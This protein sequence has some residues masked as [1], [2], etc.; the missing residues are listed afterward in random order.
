[1][2]PRQEPGQGGV[3]LPYPPVPAPVLSPEGSAGEPVSSKRFAWPFGKS[4]KKAQTQAAAQGADEHV[5]EPLGPSR[6]QRAFRA[7]VAVGVVGLLGAN[8]WWVTHPRVVVAGPQ[9]VSFP[10]TVGVDV[11]AASAV[12][13]EA[14]FAFLTLDDPKAR[15]A[16]LDVVW[17]TSDSSWDGK[18]SLTVDPARVHTVKTTVKDASSVDVL[19]AARLGADGAEAPWVGVLVPVRLSSAGASVAGAP[20]IVGLPEPLEVAAS[21]MPDTDAELT[22]ATKTDIDAFFKAWADGDVSAL[23]APGSVIDAPP[24]GLGSV[25]VESWK[26]F[27]G[28][29]PTRSGR[30]QVIWSIGGAKLAATYTLTL[31]HVSGG[32]ASRWQ[33]SSLSY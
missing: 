17:A 21:T 12:A 1:M 26:A 7:I 8:L 5:W 4:A 14:A 10:E 22:A 27:E 25:T 2:S 9:S 30:A 24:A 11:A 33:V 20:A 6:A 3:E 31:T 23:T 32:E 28:S 19:V 15:E 18:G 13:E 29:G 16:R